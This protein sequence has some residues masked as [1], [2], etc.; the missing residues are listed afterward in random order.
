MKF[1]FNI[2]VGISLVKTTDTYQ[3]LKFSV[4][5]QFIFHNNYHFYLA[6]VQLSW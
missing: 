2:K 3:Q 5:Y 6:L 1:Y 4:F